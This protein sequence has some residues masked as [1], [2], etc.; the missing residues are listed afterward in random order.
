MESLGFFVINGR[1]A[2]DTPAKF[3]YMSNRGSSV[4]DLFWSNRNGLDLV[5]NFKVVDLVSR[6]DHFPIM[7][8]MNLLSDNILNKNELKLKWK[9]HQADVY[10]EMMQWM[11]SI[12]NLSGDINCLDDNFNSS[13]VS[14]A[15]KLNMLV[16]NKNKLR[17]K[18][19]ILNTSCM[20]SKN[21][22]KMKL[23]NCVENNF[24]LEYK[25]EYVSAKQVYKRSLLES[26]KMYIDNKIQIIS[27]TKN[28]KDFW[29]EI[30]FYRKPVM[31][32]SNPI[33]IKEWC[34]FFRGK[35]ENS[36]TYNQKV[37][38]KNL[39]PLLD[40][41]IAI[42]EIY[43]VLKNCKNNKAPGAN[44]I[45]N[46]FIKNLPENWILYLN[47][48]FNKVLELEHTPN[49]WSEIII[50]ML[51][52]NKGP[53]NCPE[54][55]RPIALVNCI[56]IIFTKIV[57]NRL[58]K[59]CEINNVLPEWQNGFRRGRSCLDNI[60]T[61]NALIQFHL[62]KCKGKVYAAFIDFKSA[63]PSVKHNLLW[64]KLLK[65]GISSKIVNILIDLYSKAVMKIKNGKDFSDPIKITEGVLQGESLSPLLFSLFLQDIENFFL[66]SGIRGISLNHIT[67]ILLLGYAD[68]IVFFSE[69]YI[70]MKKIFKTLF[71]YCKINELEVNIKLGAPPLRQPLW[72]V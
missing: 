66:K 48:L 53:K 19:W 34:V 55:Y 58:T 63:F 2:D 5:G 11:N 39:N 59:W 71:E 8:E 13:I 20:Q 3:T 65:M 46:E 6:S 17:K 9:R 10:C 57:E 12:K 37:F 40:D 67:E 21:D 31:N 44:A 24:S 54:N 23:Q 30:N 52:K 70:G 29:N 33:G 68:D 50:S 51:Y 45:T 72:G 14:V 26:K 62:N 18:P 64:D 43:H 15:R 7:M 47:C 38:V 1:T 49:S 4:I 56:V 41:E 25:K 27:D 42:D 32:N 61:L 28:S 60:F 22:L 69:S 35:F 36:L 16:S